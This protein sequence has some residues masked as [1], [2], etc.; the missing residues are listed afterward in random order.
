M[1]WNAGT[2]GPVRPIAN[3]PLPDSRQ[4]KPRLTK[5]AGK[6]IVA[7][8]S[9]CSPLF[10][11]RGLA[12]IAPHAALL[13]LTIERLEFGSVCFGRHFSPRVSHV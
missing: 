11:D 9:S 4:G 8:E 6:P 10:M 13:T 1:Q 5:F 3:Q 2:L 12:S 7:A